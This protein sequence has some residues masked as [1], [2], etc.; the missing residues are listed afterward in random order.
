MHT[1]EKKMTSEIKWFSYVMNIS[2]IMV[3]DDILKSVVDYI[4]IRLNKD[5]MKVT[6]RY[7]LK[8][9]TCCKN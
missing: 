5:E 2:K 1:K 4:R 3:Y 9:K 8:C 6:K 7:C